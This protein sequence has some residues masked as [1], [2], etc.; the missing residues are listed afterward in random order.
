MKA[1]D[2]IRMMNLFAANWV[3]FDTSEQAIDL[4]TSALEPFDGALA[5]PAAMTYIRRESAPPKPAGIVAI[6]RE[7]TGGFAPDGPDAWAEVRTQMR[8]NPY[9]T[10]GFVKFGPDPDHPELGEVFL[11][12][13]IPQPTFSHPAIE[14]AAM[15]IGWRELCQSENLGITMAQFLKLYDVYRTREANAFTAVPVGGGGNGRPSRIEAGNFM[16]EVRRRHGL[17]TATTIDEEHAE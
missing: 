13:V 6:L 8:R 2:A 17:T 9:S 1:S 16:D 10:L 14:Q 15:A 5:Y 4:W 11:G 3:S 7:L 12:T